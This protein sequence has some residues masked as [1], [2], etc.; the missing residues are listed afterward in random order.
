MSWQLLR[1]RHDVLPLVLRLT[2]GMVMFP[3]GAQKLLGWG[4]ARPC[5]PGRR[6]LVGRPFRLAQ[7]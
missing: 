1:T 3:N 5:H 7:R 6:R 4:G 2:L